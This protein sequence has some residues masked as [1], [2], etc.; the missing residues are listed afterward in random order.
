M[1]LFNIA[2]AKQA[3]WCSASRGFCGAMS[4]DFGNNAAQHLLGGFIGLAYSTY[5]IVITTS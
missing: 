3:V 4:R 2:A 1:G 5:Q